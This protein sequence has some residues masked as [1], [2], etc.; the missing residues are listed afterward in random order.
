MLPACR[1]AATNRYLDEQLKQ[2]QGLL[3][4][5]PIAIA[6]EFERN[7]LTIPEKKVR[8]IFSI[9]FKIPI[10]LIKRDTLL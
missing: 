9:L 6:P 7:Y 4:N 5:S 8:N 1:Y 2:S 10:V 3:I